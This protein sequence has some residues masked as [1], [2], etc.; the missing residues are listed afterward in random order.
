VTG[1]TTYSGKKAP[2]ALIIAAAV[3]VLSA[4]GGVA[5]Y[6]YAGDGAAFT[7]TVARPE[8]VIDFFRTVLSLSSPELGRFLVIF[9]SG[10]CALAAPIACAAVGCRAFEFGYACGMA[11]AYVTAASVADVAV[12]L[13]ACLVSVYASAVAVN[14]ASAAS[15]RRVMLRDFAPGSSG[16][17]Y[18]MRMMTSTGAVIV[19]TAVRLIVRMF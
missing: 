6:I 11:S 5:C 10:F 3:F 13:F 7:D 18:I 17:E 1:E 9:A 8:S 19:A 16:G 4:A 14:F 2:A 15:G 12:A